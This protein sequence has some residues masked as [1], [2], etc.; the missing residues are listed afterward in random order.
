[1]STRKIKS[2]KMI[3]NKL[4]HQISLQKKYIFKI[5]TNNKKLQKCYNLYK[6]ILLKIVGKRIK[7]KYP[8]KRIILSNC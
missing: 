7:K 1:M 4:I 2:L 5:K 3:L 6:M 8:L